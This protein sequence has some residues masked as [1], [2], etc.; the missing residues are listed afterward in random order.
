MIKIFDGFK[1]YKIKPSKE[2]AKSMIYGLIADTGG[3]RFSKNATFP[4]LAELLTLSGEEY[5]D[6]LSNIYSDREEQERL[7]VL[8]AAERVKIKKI[9]KISPTK[10]CLH[11]IRI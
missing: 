7:A 2:A 6:L 5:Q 3:L 1:K 9:G 8:K 4:I 10:K 11:P